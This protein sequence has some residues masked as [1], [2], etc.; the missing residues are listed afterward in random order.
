MG[1]L[2]NVPPHSEAVSALMDDEL[3][4]D[5]FDHILHALTEDDALKE[6]WT[7]YHLA[8]DVLRRTA[9]PICVTSLAD[10]V[11]AALASHPPSIHVRRHVR[12]VPWLR[13]HR[14]KG[15]AAAAVVLLTLI[16][17]TPQNPATPGV[18]PPDQTVALSYTEID[19]NAPQ[20]ALINA[21]LMNHSVYLAGS[22]AGGVVPFVHL[23][24]YQE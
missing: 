7:R 11:A 23:V 22:G 21:Y 17:F 13:R 15:L 24:D 12:H 8:K 5:E 16:S 20:A 10:R 2:G 4:T 3:S 19:P 18:I 9:P 1:T 6:R 14:G